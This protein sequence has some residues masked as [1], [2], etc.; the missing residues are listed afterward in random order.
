MLAQVSNDDG[1]QV[2]FGS[3]PD[4]ADRQRDQLRSV[5]HGRGA[6]PDAPITILSDGAGG[7][8]A[9]GEAACV[10]PT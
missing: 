8:R 2:V 6:T 9:L 7:P 3:M 1:K 5:L 10:G 4:E